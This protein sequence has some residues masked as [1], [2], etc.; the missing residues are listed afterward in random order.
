ML[1]LGVVCKALVDI[2]VPSNLGNGL[3]DAHAAT[4]TA[5]AVAVHELHLSLDLREPRATREHEGLLTEVAH[6]LPHV[7][8]GHCIVDVLEHIRLPR[9]HLGDL[10]E[11]TRV[12]ADMRHLCEF[13]YVSTAFSGGA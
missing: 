9:V 2:C 11:I 7:Q 13:Q 12:N 10:V 5:A 3:N 4:V 8:L 6:V 1:T